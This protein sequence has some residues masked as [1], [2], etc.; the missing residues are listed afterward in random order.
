M[1]SNE[2][3][4]IFEKMRNTTSIILKPR[5]FSLLREY[6]LKAIG[7]KENQIPDEY[8]HRMISLLNTIVKSN[9]YTE[10]DMGNTI[11]K[12]LSS[13]AFKR[14]DAKAMA[15]KRTTASSQKT[16][17]RSS[18][19]LLAAIYTYRYCKAKGLNA[20]LGVAG[21]LGH[22]LG[23]TPMGHEGE[24]WTRNFDEENVL[25]TFT[26][27]TQAYTLIHDI[28]K[29]DDMPWQVYDAWVKHN[30]E[31]FA[32]RFPFDQRITEEIFQEDIIKAQGKCGYI[33]TLHPATHEGAAVQAIDPI[34]YIGQ[35]LADGFT[36]KVL[37]PKEMDKKLL[38][39]LNMFGLSS[40][41]I[42]RLLQQDEHRTFEVVNKYLEEFSE[43]FSANPNN[44]IAM[45][46]MSSLKDLRNIDFYSRYDFIEAI[47]KIASRIKEHAKDLSSS[48]ADELYWEYVSNEFEGLINQDTTGGTLARTIEDKL[49][50]DLIEYSSD[51]P[52][53]SEEMTYA[54]YKL[55]EYSQEEVIPLVLTTEQSTILERAYGDLRKIYA[56]I[57][58]SSGFIDEKF[59][60]Y[61]SEP[62]NQNPD[63]VLEEHT[64]LLKKYGSKIVGHTRKCSP[65]YFKSREQAILVARSESSKEPPYT[66]RESLALNIARDYIMRTR[67]IEFVDLLND[68]WVLKPEEKDE[69]GEIVRES[70]Y[71]IVTK[72]SDTTEKMVIEEGNSMYE[73][74]VG[75]QKGL[76]EFVVKKVG[77][78]IEEVQK[79]LVSIQKGSENKVKEYME[80]LS[81]IKKQMKGLISAYNNTS[82][83]DSKSAV[84]TQICEMYEK[85][86]ESRKDLFVE[87]KEEIEQ[88]SMFN[89]SGEIAERTH[90][91]TR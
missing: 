20:E 11:E 10:I 59:P 15:W 89:A 66:I 29:L 80:D 26:H 65:S 64:D 44:L 40:E 33:G 55:I 85:L 42:H 58:L 54:K 18:H 61:K 45:E 9:D 24:K 71:D 8:I 90:G 25:G 84:Y 79:S 91:E 22:D 34:A 2:L 14:L 19:V 28:E 7:T 72:R 32:I 27:N 77:Y 74:R 5:E 53:M 1:A 36:E 16:S 43:L 82:E 68:F 49:L 38:K 62:K 88:T 48:Q 6:L 23:H 31:K 4:G 37:K 63:K 47:G 51:C 69:N 30:G 86:L 87:K 46:L 70:E 73:T 83:F 35:D 39:I 76:I 21:A 81:E 41:D 52:E 67:D 50:R 60:Q 57:L 56:R 3:S 75:M 78:F 12:I 17:K 13:K